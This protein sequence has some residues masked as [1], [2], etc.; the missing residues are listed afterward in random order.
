MNCH[1]LSPLAY[2]VFLLKTIHD[3]KIVGL[4][5]SSNGRSCEQHAC[6]EV[7]LGWGELYDLCESGAKKTKSDRNQGMAGYHLLD[8]IP[9]QE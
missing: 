9:S 4:T 5:G 6:C 8:D 2:V 1:F 3:G 7:C